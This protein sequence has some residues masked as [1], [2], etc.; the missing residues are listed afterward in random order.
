MGG[1]LTTHGNTNVDKETGCPPDVS[2]LLTLKECNEELGRTSKLY[3]IARKEEIPVSL[4]TIQQMK[5]CRRSLETSEGWIEL[6]RSLASEIERKRK[7]RAGGLK[8]DRKIIDVFDD[9]KSTTLAKEE[10]LPSFVAK[11]PSQPIRQIITRAPKSASSTEK[12]DKKRPT[13]T[14]VDKNKK[15]G[16]ISGERTR[17]KLPKGHTGNTNAP[18]KK[19]GRSKSTTTKK[20]GS[21]RRVQKE[22]RKTHA[23]SRLD[24]LDP[25]PIK[26]SKSI[27]T[28]AGNF[29]SLLLSPSFVDSR[30]NIDKKL[31]SLRKVFKE[32]SILG[33]DSNDNEQQEIDE[34][35]AVSLSS[36]TDTKEDRRESIRER[37]RRRGEE[38]RR[39]RIKDKTSTSAAVTNPTEGIIR[40]LVV[41]AQLR[42]AAIAGFEG[43]RSVLSPYTPS[44]EKN[45]KRRIEADIAEKVARA[46]VVEQ[47]R[48]SAA[49]VKRK[50]LKNIRERNIREQAEA[51]IAK[52]SHVSA[53]PAGPTLHRPKT[54]TPTTNASDHKSSS[55]PKST[56]KRPTKDDTTSQGAKTKSSTSDAKKATQS[57]RKKTKGSLCSLRGS[58][59]NMRPSISEKDMKKIKDSKKLVDKA[60]KAKREKLEAELRAK[61]A[62]EIDTFVQKT[63]DMFGVIDADSSNSIEENELRNVI[64]RFASKHKEKQRK[65]NKKKGNISSGLPPPPRVAIPSIQRMSSTEQFLSGKSRGRR[66]SM[67][68]KMIFAKADA[69]YSHNVDFAEFAEFFVVMIHALFTSLDSKMQDTLDFASFKMMMLLLYGEGFTLKI[70]EQKY[71]KE[72]ISKIQ[73][74]RLSK[75]L[76][77][78]DLNVD[79]KAITREQCLLFVF[80]RTEHSMESIL[81]T[82]DK[83]E[84]VS[85]ATVWNAARGH[86]LDDI[87]KV[88]ARCEALYPDRSGEG[89]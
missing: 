20:N 26:C 16:N 88:T 3:E 8:S 59:G 51:E 32:A 56:E 70:H 60:L 55:A 62:A 36:S 19:I 54:F 66:V 80:S 33:S 65:G 64:R 25:S 10:S 45:E 61:R 47:K 73:D 5:K 15:D 23:E 49:E 53:A 38:M 28:A 42:A 48:K 43:G 89:A 6:A 71:S 83:N 17:R 81:S 85:Q 12:H 72:A 35:G 76:R 41:A 52:M 14:F 74:H 11:L 63:F 31:N 21:K 50:L 44:I 58:V 27:E 24:R 69:D 39:R 86:A 1:Q 84:G 67:L 18:P 29:N 75:L 77:H 37:F 9:S 40:R 22:E 13:K 34:K 4:M 7:I 2:D 46:A 78:F 79:T 57:K 30:E 82:F 68:S 87:K